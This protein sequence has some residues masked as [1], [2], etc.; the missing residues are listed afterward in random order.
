MLGMQVSEVGNWLD[1]VLVDLNA[2]ALMDDAQA[3]P[4][5]AP[6]PGEMRL[7][8]VLVS[9]HVQHQSGRRMVSCADVQSA[10]AAAQ[11]V[12]QHDSMH[13][14]LVQQLHS[15]LLHAKLAGSPVRMPR[16]YHVH[17]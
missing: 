8:E 11:K 9:L 14:L 6:T 7:V 15:I 17:L 16:L 13:D 1:Q 2:I 12:L 5:A 3:L 4:A 10:L